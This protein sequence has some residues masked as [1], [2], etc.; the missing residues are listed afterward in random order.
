[1]AVG[2]RLL[3]T[4]GRYR[5][6]GGPVH[7]LTSYSTSAHPSCPDSCRVSF[8]FPGAGRSAGPFLR[9]GASCDPYTIGQNSGCDTSASR[10]EQ[11]QPHP[12]LNALPLRDAAAPGS[13]LVALRIIM[14]HAEVYT[15]HLSCQWV[16]FWSS[17][18]RQS[19][20]TQKSRRD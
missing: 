5:A 15:L 18:G 6:G 17:V 19:T 20:Q 14:D 13:H 10:K 8:W 16:S 1:M 2:E 11:T 3:V 12:Q 7:E 4:W 9:T